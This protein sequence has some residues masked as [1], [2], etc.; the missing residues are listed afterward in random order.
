VFARRE[1]ARLD[2][3]LGAKAIA[4][5]FNGTLSDDEPVLC[6]I[7]VELFAEYGRPLTEAD[8]YDTLAGHSEE[9]IIGG[10]LGVEGAELARLV[11]ERIERYR[12]RVAD[13]STVR[14]HVREAVRYA[15]ERVPVGLVSG[16]FRAE[17]E[18]VLSAAGLA[19]CFRAVVTAEDVAAGKPAPDGYA[20][21][22]SR[23]GDGLA[24]EHVVAF[25]D[26]E[27]GVASAKAAGLVCIGV[28][29]TLPRERLAQADDLVDAITRDAIH[30]LL[31]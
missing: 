17:I 11:A 19:S 14:A 20:K 30:R 1:S 2:S 5:D 21:V 8:Y 29:G 18:P 26:T 25:E 9:A 23:L 15:A 6:S 13:G 3:R 4:F 7:Y 16:A 12:A 28:L 22:V 24:P 10:W 31:A 27:A